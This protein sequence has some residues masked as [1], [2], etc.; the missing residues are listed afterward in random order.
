MQ[1]LFSWLVFYTGW[2]QEGGPYSTTSSFQNNF[3]F[4]GGIGL[5]FIFFLLA[6]AAA[7]FVGYDS[8]KRGLQVPA[9]K[10]ASYVAIGLLLPAM[11]FKFTVT[12]ADV[13]GYF[14][15]Q[16]QIDELLYDP[17][18]GNRQKADELKLEQQN[19]FPPLTGLMEPILYLGLLGGL[20]GA[21]IAAAYYIT[22]QD[23]QS[24][25]T[26]V[27]RGIQQPG[28]YPPPP[29]P[30]PVSR[31]S[32]SDGRAP[33]K[34]PPSKRKVNAWLVTREGKSYQVFEGDTV[35][36]RSS[37]QTDIQFTGDT[38][39][40]SVHAKLVQQPNGRFK[41]YDLGSTNG[42][43]VNDRRVRQPVLLDPDDT[44]QLGDNTFLTFK[45]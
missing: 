3:F 6:V 42:T 19:K 40:S 24:G 32:T 39:V 25:S 12:Q 22:Y 17:V 11:L 4:G 1:S 27:P 43:R 9:Y 21:G 30:P 10:I 35:I 29:P 31:R 2:Y 41:L 26:G 8:Q 37:S 28:V 14:D 20:G 34:T 7:I 38:T 5:W 13:N 15:L 33:A 44:I 18:P 16:R 45:S 23:A 36:G